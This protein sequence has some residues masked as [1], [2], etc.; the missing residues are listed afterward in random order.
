MK[1][2]LIAFQMLIPTHHTSSAS[3]RRS[4]LRFAPWPVSPTLP[5]L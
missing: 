5:I 1:P 3:L 4:L 2:S